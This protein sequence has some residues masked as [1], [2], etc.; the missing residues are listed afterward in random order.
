LCI[1]CRVS[2]I[3]YWDFNEFSHTL[4]IPLKVGAGVKGGP[5]TG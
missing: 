2:T 3:S 5:N 1:K 4:R